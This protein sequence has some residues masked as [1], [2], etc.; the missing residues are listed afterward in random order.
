MPQFKDKINLPDK[1]ASGEVIILELGSG[2]RHRDNRVH[3]DIS[4]L[5][6]TDVI[7]DLEQGLPF[8][9]DSSIDAIHATSFLEHIKNLEF[10]MTEIYRVL[11]PNG[12][13]YAFTP[14]FSNPYYY[15]DY[16]HIRP[17]GLY[18]F[19]YFSKS[20][21]PFRRKVPKFY[22]NC[23][24]RISKIKLIFRS[25]LLTKIINSRHRFQEWYEYYFSH[26]LPCYGIDVE[27]TA[28]KND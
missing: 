17:F 5:P 27:L 1:L 8:L 21:Y 24:F 16:T 23:N 15:S 18:A 20:H 6:E 11:K 4:D 3:I 2:T 25:R 14:H 13:L 22:N 19:S 12:H 26:F 9:P 28:V 7:A 10:L